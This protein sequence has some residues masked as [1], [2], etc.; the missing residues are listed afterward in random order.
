VAERHAEI[1]IETRLQ[2]TGRHHS[3]LVGPRLAPPSQVPLSN[4]SRGVA[5]ALEKLLDGQAILL[6][7]QGHSSV[8]H[9]I[10]EPSPPRIPARQNTVSGRRAHARRRMHVGESHPL[11][12][13]AIAMRR[14]EILPTVAAQVRVAQVV[15]HDQNHI[16][17]RTLS[18][19][20]SSSCTPKPR[21]KSGEENHVALKSA[22]QVHV[23]ITT[24]QLSLLAAN[25]NEWINRVN[26]FTAAPGISQK[27]SCADGSAH[28]LDPSSPFFLTPRFPCRAFRHRVVNRPDN[29]SWKKR[30]PFMT[31]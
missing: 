21:R 18:P 16:R 10:L 26:M 31:S 17:L 27:L 24:L 7:E 11:L 22:R 19:R 15:G 2:R 25:K 14:D 9:P 5:L 23:S 13:Q 8:Q 30:S 3:L 12:R 28:S 20:R 1:V 29:A 4:A 6:D